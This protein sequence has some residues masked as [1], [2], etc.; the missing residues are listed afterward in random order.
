MTR[1]RV[2]LER[3]LHGAPVGSTCDAIDAADADEAVA[4]LIR[5]WREADPT[6]KYAPLVVRELP[7]ID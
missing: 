3:R 2:L 5:R 7:A 6:C 4:E 1:F